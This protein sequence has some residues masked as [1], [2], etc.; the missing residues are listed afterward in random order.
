MHG[1]KTTRRQAQ[2]VLAAVALGAVSLSPLTATAQNGSRSATRAT[3]DTNGD[4]ILD[5]QELR[6]SM[7]AAFA[8]ADADGDGYLTAGELGAARMA[9]DGDR[10]TRGPGFALGGRRGGETLE[11]RVKRLDTD[12]DGRVAK[13]EFLAVPH[14][15][16][17]LDDGDGRLTRDELERGRDRARK[18]AGRGVL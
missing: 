3:L 1:A 10:R 16:L 8:R 6:A 11:E 15:L 5:E 2:I 18:R 14:P 17:R 4:G 13:Q 9:G 12:R 7:E